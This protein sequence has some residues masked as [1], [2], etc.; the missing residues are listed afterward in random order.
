MLNT[1]VE[2][3]SAALVVAVPYPAKVTHIFP[4]MDKKLFSFSLLK[5]LKVGRTGKGQSVV[6]S[7][8][9]YR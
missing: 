6:A 3:G 4:I 5:M 8:Q 2:M 1:V 7:R 9:D